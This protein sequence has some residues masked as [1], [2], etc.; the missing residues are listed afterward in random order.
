M[1][2]KIKPENCIRCGTCIDECPE[3]AIG[4]GADNK[5]VV[6]PEACNGCGGCVE[7]CCAEALTL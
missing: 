3:A 7:V 6:N 5:P 4:Y 2:V 1:A